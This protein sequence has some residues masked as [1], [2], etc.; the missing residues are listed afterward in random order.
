MKKRRKGHDAKKRGSAYDDARL[1]RLIIIA[2]VMINFILLI[3][4]FEGWCLVSGDG[5]FHYAASQAM[6]YRLESGNG[7]FGNWNPIWAMGFP[8]YEYYQY[9]THLFLVILHYLTFTLVPVLV[10]EKLLVILAVAFFPVSVYYGMTRLGLG[11]LP[12]AFASLVSFA[13]SSSVGHGD[14]GFSLVNHGLFTQLLAVFLF[15]IAL[16][17]IYIS[18]SER[19]S[20]FLSVLM[21]AMLLLIHPIVGYCAFIIALV[22]F[23]CFASFSSSR[24]FLL[25]LGALLL[26]LVSSAVVV[27]HF[28]VPFIQGGDYY[29]SAFYTS[30]TD[31]YQSSM[32][33][34]VFDLV[35]GRT[36]DFYRVPFALLTLLFFIGMYAVLSGRV[37]GF[38]L[39][40]ALGGFLVFFLVSFGRS[41]WGVLFD[42]IPGMKYMLV[43]RMMFALQFFALFVVGA[44]MFFLFDSL[45]RSRSVRRLVRTPAVLLAGFLLVLALPVFVQVFLFNSGS[46]K[47]NNSGFDEYSF[48][49]LVDFLRGAP[50]GRFMARP[51]LGF[52][53]PIYEGLLPI[54]TA[55]DSFSSSSM[56]TQDNLAFYYTQ[57]FMLPSHEFFNLYNVRYALM[58]SGVKPGQAFFREAL[59]AGNYT[60]YE[61]E[62]SG[63]F[64]L[65]DSSTLLVYSGA[66][67]SDFVR[68]VNRAW[69]NT[70]AMQLKDLVTMVEEGQ[71]EGLDGYSHV[72][73]EK[74]NIPAETVLAMFR[75]RSREVPPSC[76]DVLAENMTLNHYVALV[77]TNRS[78][79]LLFKMSYHP[80]WHAVVGGE[81]VPVLAV[82][83]SFMAVP[84]EPGLSGVEF[85][86]EHD[87]TF[88]NL[89]IAF[90]LMVLVGLLLYDLGARK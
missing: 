81:S 48:S 14:M 4:L 86:Y 43:F 42:V 15:P 35:T 68:M 71:E 20:Y 90:G 63:F 30:T 7:I 17:R 70:Y 36:L 89:L 76:G 33:Q 3:P 24:S 5:T 18:L 39:T 9:F 12:A 75:D 67:N 54:Y 40:F 80:G 49:E 21:L 62:T 50:D 69:L 16:A 56:G 64:D 87:G 41:F 29:G 47:L 11:R 19:R 44:G 6:K 85:Y 32:P 74:D 60:L 82:S 59:V 57:Y 34:V 65:A 31:Y 58:P 55:H 22:M 53:S 37:R 25:S 84:V 13:L 66:M 8:T 1:A 27:S 77:N 38:P 61:I 79:L 52:T 23:F 51:E 28:Y 73:Y 72:L 83:P 88:R 45:R 2:A 46:C 10:L 26:V 78:C